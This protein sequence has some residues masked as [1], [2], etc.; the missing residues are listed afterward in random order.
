MCG[1]HCLEWVTHI[2][3]SV[4]PHLQYQVFQLYMLS[5]II[6]VVGGMANFKKEVLTEKHKLIAAHTLLLTFIYS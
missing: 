3:E 6:N 2:E 1:V 5:T 4:T